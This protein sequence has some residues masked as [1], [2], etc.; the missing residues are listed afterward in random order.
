MREK[1]RVELLAPHQSYHNAQ[2]YRLPSVTTIT[3]IGG[4]DL[5][6]WANRQGLAGIDTAVFVQRTADIGT[7]THAR[8]EAEL[9]GME[10][11]PDGL[12]PEM[13]E[14]SWYGYARFMEWWDAQN[15][16]AVENELRMVSE[17][18]QVGGTLDI[19]AREKRHHQGLILLDI[20]TSTAIHRSHKIQV[21][22]AYAP[23][24][25][26]VTGRRLDH[27]WIIR[28]GRERDQELE[29]FEIPCRP[30]YERAFRALVK[31]HHA[32]KDLPDNL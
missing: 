4:H 32:L 12:D 26:E 9:R 24:Y 21:A 17:K 14:Q 27:C 16:V 3:K 13:L 11:D 8:I 18:F 6:P 7:L 19:V 28:T 20:K 5:A 10:L 25:R 31:A 29:A 2:G 1:L 23:M 22:G 15:L 30:A